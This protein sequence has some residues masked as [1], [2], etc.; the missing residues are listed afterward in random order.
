MKH[1]RSELFDDS[2]TGIIL[3]NTSVLIRA[4]MTLSVNFFLY[5]GGLVVF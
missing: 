3:S 4:S 5:T 1:F 2:D